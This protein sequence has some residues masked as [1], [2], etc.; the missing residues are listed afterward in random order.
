MRRE[1]DGDKRKSEDKIK[2]PAL[3][4]AG[5]AICGG[6]HLPPP[7]LLLCLFPLLSCFFFGTISKRGLVDRHSLI[8][9]QPYAQH[10]REKKLDYALPGAAMVR[11]GGSRLPSPPICTPQKSLGLGLSK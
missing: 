10:G 6:S 8:L 9:I 11:S 2:K 5:A 4:S 7:S 3:E 1:L